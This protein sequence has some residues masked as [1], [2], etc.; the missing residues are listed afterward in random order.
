MSGTIIRPDRISPALCRAHPDSI[1]LFGDN[2]E[3]R[4][5]KGQA[6]IRGQPNAVGIPT[7]RRPA[8]TPDSF[9]SD[10]DLPEVEAACRGAF[11]RCYNAPHL[12]WDVWIPA[13]GLGTGLA[14]LPERAPAI[15]AYINGWI[16]RLEE[17]WGSRPY[18][19]NT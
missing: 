1:F 2:L 18:R 17:R 6:A 19:S 5:M 16:A 7:K 10:R 3:G 4:G 14:Q 9:F 15:L 11:V 12:G 13:D 8:M